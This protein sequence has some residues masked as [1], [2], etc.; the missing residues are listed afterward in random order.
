MS[1]YPDVPVASSLRRGTTRKRGCRACHGG[2]GAL[3]PRDRVHQLDATAFL[4][5]VR[6]QNMK[7]MLNRSDEL[8]PPIMSR[9][10]ECA[11]SAPPPTTATGVSAPGESWAVVGSKSWYTANDASATFSVPEKLRE[12]SVPLL[13]P[14]GVIVCAGVAQRTKGADAGGGTESGPGERNLDLRPLRCDVGRRMDSSGKV[15]R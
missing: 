12:R 7:R 6:C 1:F 9:A 3:S 8:P 4:N 13:R 14:G 10:V 5:A 2:N 11:L 15:Q